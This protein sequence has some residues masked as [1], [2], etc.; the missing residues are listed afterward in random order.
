MMARHYDEAIA[1]Y[2][3]VLTMDSRFSNARWQLGQALQLKGQLQEAIAEY[4]KTTYESEYPRMLALLSTAYASIGKRDEA[5][6]LLAQL[7]EAATR[8]YVGAYSYAL[9]HVGLGEKDKAIDDL[10]RAY[11]E[12]SDPHIVNI[13]FDPF[14]DPLRGDPR[15]E[16]LVQ[17]VFAP[18]Q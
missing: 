10:E 3:K 8:R 6:K 12:R 18:K 7:D 11:R 5:L 2:R 1:E 16:A 15:F 13:K 17:K 4:E 14:L 9:V